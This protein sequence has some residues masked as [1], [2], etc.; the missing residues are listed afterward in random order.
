MTLPKRVLVI[1]L[2]VVGA[3][4]AAALKKYGTAT[5]TYG[6]DTSARAV[7]I[8]TQQGWIVRGG[9]AANGTADSA[10]FG[11]LL[12]DAQLVVIATPIAALAKVMEELA[13]HAELLEDTLLTDTISVKV[14]VLS[15]ADRLLKKHASRF[16]GAHPIAGS[17]L[18]GA[19]HADADL[20]L[21][22]C[23]V[24][25]PTDANSG[26]QVAQLSRWWQSMGARTVERSA[27]EHDRVMANTSHL[28]HVV[29]YAL[30]H[31]FDESPE[32]L[33]LSAGGLQDTTRIAAADP[34]LWSGISMAN[35]DQLLKALDSYLARLNRCADFLRSDD[36]EGLC[37]LFRRAQQIKHE[38]KL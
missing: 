25:T 9:S 28:P 3:S 12:R 4:I 1:G 6:W 33:E 19:E 20:L 11:A 14:P 16:V 29:A 15:T 36:R 7:D 38:F 21:K 34:E 8:A 5:D 30:M 27:A 23:V 37:A 26:E 18:S 22:K 2:G 32:L 17:E 31:M 35:R 10:G 24:L 13:H